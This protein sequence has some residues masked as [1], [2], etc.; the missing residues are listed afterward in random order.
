MLVFLGIF[1]GLS[2]G[3]LVSIFTGIKH[4][5]RHRM[6]DKKIKELESELKKH[7][8]SNIKLSNDENHGK[9]SS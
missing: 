2:G 7:N 5:R 6:A 9:S 1:I 4:A 8:S 3:W